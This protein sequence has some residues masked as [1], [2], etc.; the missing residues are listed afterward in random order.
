MGSKKSITISAHFI[1]NFHQSLSILANDC[2]LQSQKGHELCDWVEITVA[3]TIARS[4]ILPSVNWRL[5]RKTCRRRRARLIC[6]QAIIRII[7][8]WMV[9]LRILRL[10]L[11]RCVLLALEVLVLGPGPRG[12]ADR[13]GKRWYLRS[14]RVVIWLERLR[15]AGL[16]VASILA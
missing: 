8:I 7:E 11:L 10:C 15:T 2:L 9:V 12:I 4:T 13:M 3:L 5:V 1:A 16:V 14:W 6:R